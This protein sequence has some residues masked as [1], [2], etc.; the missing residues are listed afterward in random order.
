MEPGPDI[1]NFSYGTILHA[2]NNPKIDVTLTLLQKS[3]LIYVMCV[4]LQV[5]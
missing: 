4:L 2:Y 3:V 1:R 5:M